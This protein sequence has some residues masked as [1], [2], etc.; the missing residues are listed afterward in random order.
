M[1]QPLRK[2]FSQSHS[3]RGGDMIQED[4]VQTYVDPACEGC[5]YYRGNRHIKTCEYMY[6]TGHRRGCLPGKDCTKKVLSRKREKA[7]DD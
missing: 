5:L 6:M 2:E 3:M 7:N 1:K 4:R